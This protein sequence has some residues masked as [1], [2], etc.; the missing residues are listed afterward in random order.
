MKSHCPDQAVASKEHLT[1]S[2]RP[3]PISEPKISSTHRQVILEQPCLAFFSYNRVSSFTRL[4]LISE[5][6]YL[7]FLLS[8]S[9]VDWRWVLE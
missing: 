9:I 5:L 7:L 2:R 4:I 8:Q 3:D 6:A 1:R